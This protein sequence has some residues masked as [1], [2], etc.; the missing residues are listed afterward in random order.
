MST[1]HLQC[2]I[3]LARCRCG[4]T[5][6]ALPGADRTGRCLSCRHHDDHCRNRVDESSP[7]YRLAAD[8]ATYSAALNLIG[9]IGERTLTSL[10]A[11]HR[12]FVLALEEIVEVASAAVFGVVRRVPAGLIPTQRGAPARVRIPEEIA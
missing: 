9:I 3:V 1:G 11:Q 7:G 4:T 2:E 10:T 12:Q 6:P 8:V 5:F